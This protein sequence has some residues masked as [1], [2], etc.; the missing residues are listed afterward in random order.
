MSKLP[1]CSDVHISLEI[2]TSQAD[3]IILYSGFK[4]EDPNQSV[5]KNPYS[6]D[7]QHNSL[8][9]YDKKL[10]LE[11]NISDIENS[12][13]D[14]FIL[15][16]KP[17]IYSLDLHNYSTN[18]HKRDSSNQLYILN[19]N[20]NFNYPDFDYN[21]K[22]R[23]IILPEKLKSL[24]LNSEILDLNE[25]YKIYSHIRTRNRRRERRRKNHLPTI[26]NNYYY[27][28]TSRI[29]KRSTSS[30]QNNLNKKLRPI[31][32]VNSPKYHKNSY[33]YVKFTKRKLKMSDMILLELQNGHPKLTLDLGSGPIILKINSTTSLAD[34]T[35]HRLDVMWKEG[36]S[37]FKILYIKFILQI[38]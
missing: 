16:E 19:E 1:S 28:K 33:P 34:N 37:I 32:N 5:T 2:L 35:W 30:S 4:D 23:N 18:F 6:K 25:K 15:N 9:I 14:Q 7:Q 20:F 36:V 13:S 10:E 24:N 8:K 17:D 3:A 38:H 21:N 22:S 31:L 11:K 29:Q 26:F 12:R 27:L